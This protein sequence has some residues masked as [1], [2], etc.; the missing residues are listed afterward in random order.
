M[1]SSRTTGFTL[2]ELLAVIL[3]VLVLAAVIIPP[4]DGHRRATGQIVYCMSNLKQTSVALRLW[5]EQHGATF[6]PQLSITNGGSMELINSGGPAP[7][8][9][10]LSNFL[11]PDSAEHFVCPTDQKKKATT[12]SF[13]AESN[14]S[15]FLNVDAAPLQPN[16]ATLIL[17]GD[18]HLGLAGNPVPPGLFTLTTNAPLSWTRELHRNPKRPTGI[19]LCLDGHVEMTRSN[20]ASLVQRQP[21]ATNRLAIP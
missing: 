11:A 14:I 4:P 7:H 20:L 8:F 9:Q 15:Y 6:P 12:N 16:P 2:V 19:L 13:L 5:S 21:L 10:T 3:I 1:C 17:A 18:R